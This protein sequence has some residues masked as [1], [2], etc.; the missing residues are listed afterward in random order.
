[1][2]L[3]RTDNF[4]PK[5]LLKGWKPTRRPLAPPPEVYALPDDDESADN[6]MLACHAWGRWP[7]F[8]NR[9]AREYNAPLDL[10]VVVLFLWDATVGVNG[11][12]GTISLN[13]FPS[14]VRRHHLIKWLAA[15]VSAELFD[16][17][18]AGHTSAKGSHYFYNRETEP[19][20]WE[21][22]FA[23][24]E[25]LQHVS[26]W[27]DCS[28]ETFAWLFRRDLL[29]SMDRPLNKYDLDRP[30]PPPEP[31]TAKRV[32]QFIDKITKREKL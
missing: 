3:E 7:H 28:T 16:V 11:S 10:V 26:G 6:L 9:L 2:V 29:T 8:L 4:M 22:F 15:L 23:R 19:K 20:V 30:L 18:K 21:S 12:D 13:Q 27:D 17:N 31:E 32:K 14:T 25:Q 24:A 1:M 5:R